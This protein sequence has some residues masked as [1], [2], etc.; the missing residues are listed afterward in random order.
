MFLSQ[1]S[2]KVIV[3]FFK[4]CVD[5]IRQCY[6]SYIYVY[7]QRKIAISQSILIFLNLKGEKDIN[8][9]VYLYS[10]NLILSWY[11]NKEKA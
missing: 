1:D 5:E 9:F 4:F 8:I 3:T 2:L 10:I 7:E 6:I 11:V